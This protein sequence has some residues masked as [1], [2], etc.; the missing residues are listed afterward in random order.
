MNRAFL[1]KVWGFDP[2]TVPTIGFNTPAGRK[3]FRHESEYGDWLYLAG[4]KSFPTDP[5]HQGKLLARVKLGTQE[6]NVEKVLRSINAFIPDDHYTDKGRYKWP[7]G[8]PILEAEILTGQPDLKQVVGSYLSGNQWATY[9]LD[10]EATLGLEVLEALESLEAEPVSIVD[11]P[12]INKHKQFNES[13]ALASERNSGNTGPG[14]SLTRSGSEI[15]DGPVSAY[16]M[17]FLGSEKSI[18]KVGYSR[19]PEKRNQYLNRG[20][21]TE[22]TGYSWKLTH[23]QPFTSGQ[24]AYNF[25]QLVHEQLREKLVDGQNEIYYIDEE[26]LVRTWHDVFCEKNWTED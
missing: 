10:V 15:P 25:E 1:T 16:I 7:F 17:Q 21:I 22:L 24:L 9:A 5:A 3:K 13:L 18:Y 26:E 19:D 11:A 2:T 23:Q 12:E 6:I 14:P 4:T 20:L 8:L